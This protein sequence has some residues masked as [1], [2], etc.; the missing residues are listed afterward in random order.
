[1]AS[2]MVVFSYFIAHWPPN[3]GQLHIFCSSKQYIFVAVAAF[4]YTDIFTRKSAEMHSWS[5]GWQD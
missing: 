5:K 1:M 4:R 3:L 2:S